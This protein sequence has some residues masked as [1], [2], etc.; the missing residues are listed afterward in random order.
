MERAAKEF[1]PMMRQMFVGMGALSKA[2]YQKYGNEAL[3]IITEVASQSGV[4][5]GKMM[6]QMMPARGMKTVG[7]SLKMMGAMMG[8]DMQMLE[9]SDNVIHFKTQQCPLGIQGTSKAL[10]EAM[11][12]NDRKMIGTFLG[13]EVDMK[14]LKSVAA[15]D[16]ECEVI[17]SKK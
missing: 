11:M 14:I 1:G 12:N 5:Y 10:C 8:I 16:R 7:E 9:L 2:F 13:Q 4:E 15:R 3:P 17:Y 6:Q